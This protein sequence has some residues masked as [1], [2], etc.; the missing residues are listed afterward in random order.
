MVRE[1]VKVVLKELQEEKGIE[2]AIRESKQYLPQASGVIAD[3]GWSTFFSYAADIAKLGI[4][5]PKLNSLVDVNA[6]ALMREIRNT[7][8]RRE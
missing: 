8:E 6:H 2:S 3:N 4:S 7:K 5:I 1:S